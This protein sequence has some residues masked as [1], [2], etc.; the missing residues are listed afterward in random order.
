MVKHVLLDEVLLD[1]AED[2]NLPN[3]ERYSLVMEYK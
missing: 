2:P 3:A 1:M